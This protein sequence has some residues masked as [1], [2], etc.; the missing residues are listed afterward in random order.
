MKRI[1]KLTVVFALLLLSVRAFAQEARQTLICGNLK[2]YKFRSI[3]IGY[4]KDYLNYQKVT[5]VDDM[6]DKEGNFIVNF[7][8]EKLWPV[9]FVTDKMNITLLINPGDS[10]TLTADASNFLKTASFTGRGSK[11]NNFILLYN[12]NYLEAYQE[13]RKEMPEMEEQEF[14]TANSELYKSELNFF[15][16]NFTEENGF[17]FEDYK[18][19]RQ[20]FEY[21]RAIIVYTYYNNILDYARSFGINYS[22]N[23]LE[24]MIDSSDVDNPYAL[25]SM[26]YI[27]FLSKY[28][29]YVMPYHINPESSVKNVWDFKYKLAKKVYTTNVRDLMLAKILKSAF[30]YTYRINAV[31]LFNDYQTCYMNKDYYMAIKRQFMDQ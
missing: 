4:I 22:Q 29:D 31:I 5:L 24:G 3:T 17:T 8:F 7:K 20:V 23:T 18:D 25:N 16:K 2:H 27:D 1:F 12:L 28:L 14:L 9:S 6:T 19:K 15:D 11:V 26:I 10:L 13:L 21:V 30:E